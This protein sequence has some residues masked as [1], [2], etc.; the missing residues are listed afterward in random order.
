[1]SKRF[2]LGTTN[3]PIREPIYFLYHHA[4]EL[5][6]KAF[7]TSRSKR[8]SSSHGIE[9]LYE[10]SRKEGLIVKEDHDLEVHNL[11]H[12][13]AAGNQD[14]FYRYPVENK[15]ISSD[16]AWTCDVVGRLVE[17]VEPSAKSNAPLPP[18][19]RIYFGKPVI[20]EQPVP[21]IDDG[22]RPRRGAGG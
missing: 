22:D 5:V 10:A 3:L 6:L 14:H 18:T 15:R 20:T 19:K 7:L 12:L 9:A 4:A 16:L 1:L 21:Q 13:L 2:E 11:I 8:T 17:A